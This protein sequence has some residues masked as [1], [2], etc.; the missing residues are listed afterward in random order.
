MDTCSP[1]AGP[2]I[3]EMARLHKRADPDSLSISMHHGVREK[4]YLK[5]MLLELAPCTP[6][7]V[8]WDFGR[9]LV[10]DFQIQVSLCPQVCFHSLTSASAWRTW[11]HISFLQC[12]RYSAWLWRSESLA[13]R[14]ERVMG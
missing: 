3:A 2:I 14:R 7:G 4:G 5:A 11:H 10:A 6:L 1:P 8:L 9:P 12:R 13:K